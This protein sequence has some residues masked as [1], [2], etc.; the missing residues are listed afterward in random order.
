[1]FRVE[2][3]P[4]AGGSYTD[5]DKTLSQPHLDDL[6]E[7]INDAVRRGVDKYL[8]SIWSP[9][10]HMKEVY[11]A[12]TTGEPNYRPRLKTVHYDLF[13]S[14]VVDAL[15]YLKSKGC[16]PP[17][18]LSLQNE[19]EAGVVATPDNIEAPSAFIDAVGLILL[20]NK[21]RTALN[22]AGLSTVKL[23][24][25]ESVSYEGAWVFKYT[26]LQDNRFYSDIDIH[27]QHAY[28]TLSYDNNTPE[29]VEAPLTEF[30]RIKKLIGKESW[31]TEFSVSTAEGMDGNTALQRMMIAMRMFSSDMVHAGYVVWMWWCG[32]FPGWNIDGRD[33]QVL[34]G[35]DGVTAVQKSMMFEA[36]ATIFKNAPAGS[37]VR[38]VT[39]NDPALK[40]NF[41]IMN[42]LV[43][44]QTPTGTFVLLVNADAPKTY[45]I[46][47]L[48]GTAG[49]RTSITGND[50]KTTD[51]A[52][53]TVTG[54]MAKVNVPR[55]SVNFI[56]TQGS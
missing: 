43:A 22:D 51:S 50:A 5:A 45:Y 4:Q 29:D 6:A 18:A 44:F 7:H 31:Q 54:G 39:T 27:M 10:F 46:S 8:V 25:P 40:T 33:Q 23:A 42:D 26:I 15:S 49:T 2:L 34:V 28:T 35:G 38:K 48:T 1:M 17:V 52:D 32:W 47:G 11:N 21:M 16:P 13:V 30:L 53:F 56:Y 37:H 20:I 19:P 9:P 12:S 55:N 14:Y 41:R 24:A 3:V 36:F